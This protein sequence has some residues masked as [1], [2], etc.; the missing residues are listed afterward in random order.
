MEYLVDPLEAKLAE[1]LEKMFGPHDNMVKAAVKL[2]NIPH[3]ESEEYHMIE[4]MRQLN[5]K[6]ALLAQQY[7]YTL[8]ASGNIV[9]VQGSQSRVPSNNVTI[10]DVTDSEET[11]STL[12]K[13]QQDILYSA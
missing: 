7:S 1:S 13:E 2:A 9:P 5:A 4:Q 3:D 12:P 6:E 10:T 11:A 8:D